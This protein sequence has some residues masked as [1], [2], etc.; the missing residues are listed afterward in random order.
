MDTQE[1]ILGLPFRLHTLAILAA[2]YAQPDQ[3]LQSENGLSDADLQHYPLCAH[4]Y[5]VCCRP[6]YRLY[7]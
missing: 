6:T 5:S 7:D 4:D 2:C 1:T 3:L